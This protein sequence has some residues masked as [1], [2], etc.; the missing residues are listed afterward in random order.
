MVRMFG[1]AA[2][3]IG[4]GMLSGGAVIELLDKLGNLQGGSLLT[5]VGT[6]LA[7]LALIAFRKVPS[8]RFVAG[9]V[10]LMGAAMHLI[11]LGAALDAV[12][13]HGVTKA[14][15]FLYAAVV[16]AGAGVLTDVRLVTALAIV[17]FAQVLDTGTAYWHAVYAFYSPEPTLSVLQ[18]ALLMLACGW[19]VARWSDRIGRHAGMLAIMAFVVANLSCLVGSLWGDSIGESW[20]RADLSGL[21]WQAYRDAI[22]AFQARTLTISGGVYAVIWAIGLA[23]MAAWAAHRGKRGLF[24]AAMTFAA[25]HAYTQAFEAFGAEPLVFVIGGLAA[26][27]LAWGLWQLDARVRLA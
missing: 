13:L 19:A 23:A 3:L 15:F 9:A 7:A 24:N 22:D 21:G 10:L 14:V 2:A 18:M 27:P 25:I 6:A 11:G 1:T 20:I 17:P 4:A 8:L 26:V 16:T 12:G 5:A